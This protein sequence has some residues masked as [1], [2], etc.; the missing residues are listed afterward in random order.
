MKT[1]VE[2]ETFG[3]RLRRLRKDNYLRPEELATLAGMS[4]VGIDQLETGK[5]TDP[6]L[7]TVKALAQALG[8]TEQELIGLPPENSNG[9]DDR[10][11]LRIAVAA[12][13]QQ[14]ML[15]GRDSN[16]QPTDYQFAG[17]EVIAY[18]H[19]PLSRAA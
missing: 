15:R 10:P 2:E 5:R 13:V 14:R 9:P 17:L 12:R 7:S 3:Q 18:C 11:D 16:P 1:E 6:R 4:R 19:A 8:V